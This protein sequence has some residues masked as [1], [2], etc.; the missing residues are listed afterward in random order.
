KGKRSEYL[1]DEPK[2]NLGP[3]PGMPVYEIHQLKAPVTSSI[4][5][6]WQNTSTESPSPITE[7][8]TATRA[9]PELMI[10]PITHPSGSFSLAMGLLMNLDLGPGCSSS[11]SASIPFM[12]AVFRRFLP[13]TWRCISLAAESFLLTDESR[14]MV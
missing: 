10:P 1:R 13:L 14:P 5:R 6:D 4:I 3:C 8:P 7:E 9:R 12:A 11:T 2:I